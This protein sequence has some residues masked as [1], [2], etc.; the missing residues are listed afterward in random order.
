MTERP[1]LFRPELVKAILD[2]R[3]TQTRRLVKFPHMNPLGQWEPSTVG[4]PGCKDKYGRPAETVYPVIWHTRTGDVL[5]SPHG[6]AGDR[7]WVR[8][9]FILRAGGKAVVYYADLNSCDAAGI[10]GLYGGW[11]PSIHMPRWA[12]RLTLEIQEVRVER[13]QD[14]SEKDAEAEG[15]FGV[16]G[17]HVKN[18]AYVRDAFQDLWDLIHAKDGYGWSANPWVWVIAFKVVS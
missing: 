2:G 13:V 11:K 4:G 15:N 16:P 10:G 12:S 6:N 3:K 18:Y 17:N 9:R 7:L 14:I 1:I 5:S 8:E